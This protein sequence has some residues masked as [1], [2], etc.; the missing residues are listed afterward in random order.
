MIAANEFGRLL[1]DWRRARG[2]SQMNLALDA[3]VSSRHLS[4]IENGRST[5]SRDMVLRL[6]EA[7]DV[8]LR[9]RNRFL[10][11]AGYASVYRQSTLDDEELEPALNALRF[12]LERH[13][14]YPAFV[15]DRLWNL[16]LAN[17]ASQALLR[18][19][20]IDNKAST[21]PQTNMLRLVLHPNGLKSRLEN[22][23]EVAEA[24]LVRAR[25][26][27]TAAF[28][29]DP[30]KELLREI[31][32]YPGVRELLTRLAH[33]PRS[34]PVIPLVLNLDGQRLSWF[35]VIATFGTPQDVTL[36]EIR[37]ETLAPADAATERYAREAMSM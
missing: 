22:W 17:H 6:A 2:R 24:L 15:V 20:G 35:T 36:Q 4:F 8:P 19:C 29:D 14:P 32:A 28:G 10:N 37:L 34:A 33:Q 7:L 30:L 31:E 1:K 3:E 11:A 9:D 13:E 16:L 18:A 25:Q 21:T 27:A 5:P 26:E 12:M 23:H